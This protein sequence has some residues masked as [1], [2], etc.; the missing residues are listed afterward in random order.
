[1][2]AYTF[3]KNNFRHVSPEEYNR[4]SV[5]WWYIEDV[6]GARKWLASHQIDPWSKRN[7]KQ[8]NP[9]CASLKKVTKLIGQ[10]SHWP[11]KI[12]VIPRSDP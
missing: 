5:L 11:W 4:G 6:D 9:I 3:R 10:Q 1:M 12:V 7:Q 8:D 2:D